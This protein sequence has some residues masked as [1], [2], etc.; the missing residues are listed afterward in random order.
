MD[1][2]CCLVKP[3]TL[4][5]PNFFLALTTILQIQI[6]N[7]QDLKRWQDLLEA[8]VTSKNKKIV[9]TLLTHFET[10]N[11]DSSSSVVECWNYVFSSLKKLR[12]E[13]IWT[14]LSALPNI[15]NEFENIKFF[16]RGKNL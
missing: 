13:K 12:H 7:P 11:I 10:S 3:N 8:S 14:Y 9:G 1:D 15:H 2:F 16:L 6:P 5:R 4:N